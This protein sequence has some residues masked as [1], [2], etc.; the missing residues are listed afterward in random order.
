MSKKKIAFGAGFT[1]VEILIVVAIIAILA[2]AIIPNY[3]GFDVDARVVTTKSN[4]ATVRNRISLYRAKEGKYPASLGDLMK[5]TY[6]D[7]GID[8]PYL[9]AM[10]GELI[11]EKSGNSTYQDQSST[12]ALSGLGGW[13]YYTDKAD[14][15]INYGKPLDRSWEDYKDQVPSDW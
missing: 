12:K 14:I 9:K 1:L 4:L 3:V 6:S 5:E 11:S 2:L 13:V 7:A 8:K 15:V 10:P